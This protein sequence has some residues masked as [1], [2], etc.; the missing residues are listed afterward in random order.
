MPRILVAS[1]AEF[2]THTN[3]ALGLQG[4]GGRG[5]NELSEAMGHH[6]AL[7]IVCNQEV[8][9]PPPLRCVHQCWCQLLSKAGPSPGRP[10]RCPFSYCSDKAGSLAA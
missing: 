8:N 6:G 10:M 7:A 2:R 3:K 9:L 5:T 4:F 1:E